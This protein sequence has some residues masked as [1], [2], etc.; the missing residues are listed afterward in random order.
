MNVGELKAI[1]QNVDEALEVWV[2]Y[3]GIDSNYG[4]DAFV[5]PPEGLKNYRGNGETKFVVFTV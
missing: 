1:L 5:V 4:V 2:A 3:E